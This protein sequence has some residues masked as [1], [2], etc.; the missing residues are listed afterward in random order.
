MA[1]EQ[2]VLHDARIRR[3]PARLRQAIGTI[4]TR[5]FARDARLSDGVVRSY[6][7]GLTFPTLDRLDALAAAAGVTPE[8][9]LTG[10][11]PIAIDQN[12]LKSAIHVFDDLASREGADWDVG[13]R[14][15]LIAT[16]YNHLYFDADPAGSGRERVF[17]LVRSIMKALK[18]QRPTAASPECQKRD[19]NPSE[20]KTPPGTSD[21]DI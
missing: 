9:L 8:W 5:P 18:H 4:K 11:V 19:E 2:R 16:I 15:E 6:L 20:K 17:E 21:A 1:T 10:D 3:F 14:S 7:N 12:L 13:A